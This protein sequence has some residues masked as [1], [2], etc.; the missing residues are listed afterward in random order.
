[1]SKFPS[2]VIT[3]ILRSLGRNWDLLSQM[4][5]TDLRGRYVGSSLGLFWSVIHPLVMII[6]YTLV[7]SRVMGA[8]LPG[9][10]DRYA[11][12]IY[13]C[14]GLLPWMAFQELVQRSTT[15]FPDN[16]GL[17]RKVAFP[18]V[19]LYGFVTLSSAINF[20]LAVGVFVL[21]LGLSGHLLPATALLW[22]PLVALQLGFALG[23]G[24]IMS[25]L[26]VFVRD[27]AQLVSVLLQV[28]FWMTPIVYVDT[29]LPAWA[30]RAELLNPLFVFSAA[31]RSV[32]LSGTLPTLASTAGLGALTVVTL[33]AGLA[34]YRRF[35]ADILDE[36]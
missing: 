24:M 25:V 8:R 5:M 20:G 16:A 23:L 34:L 32:V 14:S 11:Y 18:K 22:L 28:W 27:T 3:W 19:V 36:L 31:H 2:G 9:T 21:V 30:Q 10:V 26:H 17:V 6:I 33:A 13:L 4:V 7:F 12:S 15:I 1:V 29:I 35:R